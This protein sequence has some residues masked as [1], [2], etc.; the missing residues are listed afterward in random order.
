METRTERT[1]ADA[2]RNAGWAAVALAAGG[3]LLH[4]IT[5]ST[6]THSWTADAGLSLVAGAGLMTLAIGL[7]AGPWRPRTT[8]WIAIVGAAY[9]TVVA[10]AFVL[11]VLLE[12]AVPPLDSGHAGHGAGGAGLSSAEVV[13]TTIELGLVGVLVWLHRLSGRHGPEISPAAG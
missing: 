11:L 9:T 8:G 4:W 2:M 5:T 7:S 3:S 13:R 6:D 1:N 10:L 12:P